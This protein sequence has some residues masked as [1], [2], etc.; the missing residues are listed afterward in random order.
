MQ[1]YRKYFY[2]YRYVGDGDNDLA[3]YISE[4][5]FLMAQ[6]ASPT[7]F[8]EY[9]EDSGIWKPKDLSGLLSEAKDFI[10]NLITAVHLGEDSSG[11][12]ND[13]TVNNIS[14]SRP[15]YGHAY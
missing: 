8:G 4:V 1:Y 2:R 5:W 7:D 11:N 10:I 15:S 13:A 9:D 14:S 12:G 6:Q 3:G